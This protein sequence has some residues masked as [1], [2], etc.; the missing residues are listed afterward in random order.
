MLFLF[1]FS[2]CPE[3]KIKFFANGPSSLEK[4]MIHD[5]HCRR[6]TLTQPPLHL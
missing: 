4:A 6:M 5:V 2:L 3:K 1:F